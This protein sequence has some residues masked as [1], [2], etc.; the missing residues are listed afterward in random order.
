MELQ[1]KVFLNTIEA[2]LYV[3]VSKRIIER[4]IASA[5][6]TVSRF[7]RRVLIKRL[8]LEQF[9]YYYEG[10]AKTKTEKR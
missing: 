4:M 5:T 6:I 10:N 3:R 9:M 1:Q 2:A 7:N 8:D